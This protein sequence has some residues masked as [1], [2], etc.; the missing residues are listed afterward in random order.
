MI[1][2]DNDVDDDDD[3]DDND[4]RRLMREREADDC[5][6]PIWASCVSDDQ[7]T[8]QKR[9]KPRQPT[10]NERKAYNL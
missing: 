2:A 7:K 4:R 5:E 8:M 1:G 9:C 6:Q 10:I 3:D